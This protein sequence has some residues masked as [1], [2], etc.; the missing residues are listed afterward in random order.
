MA[1]RQQIQLPLDF[2]QH[3]KWVKLFTGLWRDG[4]A[5]WKARNE[6]GDLVFLC[7]LGPPEYAITG[8]DGR[9]LSDRWAESLKLKDIAKGLWTDLA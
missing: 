4:F 9:E 7:E 5:H 2:P 6:T 3:A 8:A 1:S